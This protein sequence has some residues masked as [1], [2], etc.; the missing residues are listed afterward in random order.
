MPPYNFELTMSK[1]AG[2]RLF[3]RNEVFDRETLWTS[4]RFEGEPVGF[5]LRSYGT[6]ERPRIQVR[7]YSKRPMS[8]LSVSKLANKIS[9]LIGADDELAPFYSMARGDGV[10]KHTLDDL[11]GMHKTLRFSLFDSV[12]LGV[13][14]QM[15]TLRRTL[16]MMDSI[17]ATYGDSLEFDGR[18]MLTAPSPQRIARL[19][20]AEFSRACKLGYRGRYIV[21]SAKI[22]T[23]G[24]PDV[25]ELAKMTP[26][27]AKEKIMELP[28]LGDFSADIASPHGGF[29][30]DA[31]SVHVFSVLLFGKD[32]V[33]GRGAIERVKKAGIN[34]WGRWSW[35]AFF[36]VAQDIPDLSARLGVRLRPS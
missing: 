26:L 34:R 22:I 33:D 27:E 30:I 35:M 7:A 13:C 29:P 15:A 28:G 4:A 16:S 36:Y 17:D 19:D 10:L 9:F 8:S 31:W 20:V 32:T 21:E 11:Y 25:E 14:L 18:R 6:T 5:R 2:W 24:F 1:P 3:N 12:I 23:H